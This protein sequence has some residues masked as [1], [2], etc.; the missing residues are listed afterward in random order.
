MKPCQTNKMLW[1]AKK[2]YLPEILINFILDCYREKQEATKERDKYDKNS[3]KWKIWD[4]KRTLAKVRL[5]SIFGM[6]MTMK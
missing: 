1:K 2:D 3:E 5:N 4:T 6:T